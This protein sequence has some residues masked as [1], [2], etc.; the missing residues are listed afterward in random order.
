MLFLGKVRTDN[1]NHLVFA[2]AKHKTIE[3]KLALTAVQ[4]EVLSN[5]VVDML[6]KH[7][8]ETDR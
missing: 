4:F 3:I 7:L 2:C 1:V 8:S 5:A 6:K